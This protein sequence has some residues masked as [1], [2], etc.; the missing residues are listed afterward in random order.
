MKLIT[1]IG[2]ICL[3]A[4]TTAYGLGAIKTIKINL[5][6]PYAWF[7]DH[8]VQKVTTEKIVGVSGGVV[9]VTHKRDS[10]QISADTDFLTSII[11]HVSA[12]HGS[13]YCDIKINLQCKYDPTYP[14]PY[15]SC[16][17]KSFSKSG[18]MCDVVDHITAVPTSRGVM[19]IIAHDLPPP[20]KK[21]SSK[22]K[23]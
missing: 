11:Y 19:S 15:L 20:P 22:K 2:A 16:V 4:T 18:N 5:T 10:V 21:K 17:Y 6:Y 23:I 9:Q 1:V 13:G 8:C 14:Y 3:M 7:H 12:G